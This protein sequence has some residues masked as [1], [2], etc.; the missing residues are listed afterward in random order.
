MLSN[1]H[2]MIQARMEIQFRRHLIAVQR[3]WRMGAFS[4]WVVTIP[5]IAEEISRYRSKFD[6]DVSF[7]N[8]TKTCLISTMDAFRRILEIEGA[9]ARSSQEHGQ[10][11]RETHFKIVRSQF[12]ALAAQNSKPQFT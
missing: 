7:T 8:L 1:R 3:V 2:R 9:M 10:R 11:E 5:L 6:N 4:L 12:F